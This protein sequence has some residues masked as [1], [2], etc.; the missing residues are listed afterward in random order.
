[1]LSPQ[2]TPALCAFLC[3]APFQLRPTPKRQLETPPLPI[4]QLYLQPRLVSAP[5]LSRVPGSSELSPIE[6]GHQ[7]AGRREQQVSARMCLPSGRGRGTPTKNQV[8]LGN[9]WCL[10][11]PQGPE[12]KEGAAKGPA[13]GGSDLDCTTETPAGRCRHCWCQPSPT[14]IKSEFGTR[15]GAGLGL[16]KASQ[17]S[18]WVW[19]NPALCWRTGALRAGRKLGGVG[20][21]WL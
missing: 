8:V 18:Q 10:R 19:A 7:R 6:G 4:L 12:V 16:G 5:G 20:G 9:S 11:Q 13:E 3:C 21:P 15:K 17:W 1:M 2:T 14:P